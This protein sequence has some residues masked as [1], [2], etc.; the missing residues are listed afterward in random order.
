METGP[1]TEARAQTLHPT[2]GS[3]SGSRAALAGCPSALHFLLLMRLRLLPAD[4]RAGV[5]VS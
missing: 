2:A 5:Q 4:S 3:A 1:G